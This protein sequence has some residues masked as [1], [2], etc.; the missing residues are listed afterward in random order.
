M[1]RGGFDGFSVMVLLV[2]VV[3]SLWKGKGEVRG[4]MFAWHKQRRKLHFGNEEGTR[5]QKTKEKKKK[6]EREL[7]CSISV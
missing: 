4:R 3:N 5:N 1:W 7:A 2:R 6:E